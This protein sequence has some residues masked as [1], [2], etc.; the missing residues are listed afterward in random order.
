MWPSCCCCDKCWHVTLSGNPCC[1]CV[2]EIV[3][4]VFYYDKFE[5]PEQLEFVHDEDGHYL[6]VRIQIP[7]APELWVGLELEKNLDDECVWRVWAADNEDGLNPSQQYSELLTED[8]VGCLTDLANYIEIDP[9]LHGNNPGTTGVLILKPLWREAIPKED[10]E[11]IC[12]G[13]DCFNACLCVDYIVDYGAGDESQLI[14]TERLC[15]DEDKGDKGGWYVE[16]PGSDNGCMPARNLLFEIIDD[17]T[18]QCE[19]V[20]TDTV[21]LTQSS[22]TTGTL[23]CDGDYTGI[24]WQYTPTGEK[25]DAN[26][27]I[28]YEIKDAACEDWCEAPCCQFLPDELTAL[29]ELDDLDPG[30]ILNGPL[31]ITLTRTDCTNGI[32]SSGTLTNFIEWD[33]EDDLGSPN[34]GYG[35]ISLTII[36][37][38]EGGDETPGAYCLFSPQENQCECDCD[39]TANPA[40]SGCWQIQSLYLNNFDC[41]NPAD[42]TNANSPGNLFDYDSK[43]GAFQSST[44]YSQCDPVLLM[45]HAPVGG[46]SN[47]LDGWKITVTE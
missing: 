37:N 31:E 47:C 8:N 32:Y 6:P 25:W 4:Y 12:E 7:P 16:F 2:P 42:C 17:G 23:N 22:P 44:Y 29:I 9:W 13:C 20:V 10:G 36:C 18:G 34:A 3:C 39:D 24:V 14:Q 1:R 46:L 40:T 28:I 33:C 19:M 43:C 21:V 15:W 26:D 41:Y 11:L 38:R 30:F 5:Y 35:D 27:K 45:F